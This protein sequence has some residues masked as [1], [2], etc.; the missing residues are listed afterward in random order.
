REDGEFAVLTRATATGVDAAEGIGLAE[1]HTDTLDRPAR[2]GVGRAATDEEAALELR[3]DCA[4]RCRADGHDVGVRERP[5]LVP[6]LLEVRALEST[7]EDLVR[8]GRDD[9]GIDPVV[10]S[11]DAGDAELRILE[12]RRGQE[13]ADDGGPGGHAR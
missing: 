3:V 1:I 6:P 5:A 8:P 2:R 10:V 7:V 11:G 4:D 13:D 12:G 9:D